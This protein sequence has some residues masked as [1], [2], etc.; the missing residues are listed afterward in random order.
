MLLDVAETLYGSVHDDGFPEFG[1]VYAAALEVRLP[2][3]LARRVELR[4]AGFV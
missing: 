2:A 4:R 1:D 3:D